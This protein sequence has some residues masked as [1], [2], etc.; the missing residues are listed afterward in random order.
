MTLTLIGR[1]AEQQQLASELVSHGCTGFVYGKGITFSSGIKS[2]GVYGDCRK[3]LS[4]PYLRK[5]ILQ[6]YAAFVRQYRFSSITKI[7]FVA[8]VETGGIGFGALIAHEMGLPYIGVRKE[9]KGHGDASWFSGETELV[10][11][12]PGLLVEDMTT[13][14][15]SLL[16]AQSTLLE[17]LDARV[18]D[19][20]TVFSYGFPE[21]LAAIEQVEMHV[22]TLCT[23]DRMLRFAVSDDCDTQIDPAYQAL[24]E[25]WL[26]N[27]HDES[28]V[29]DDWSFD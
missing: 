5:L 10:R 14:A 17:Q 27:P 23:F 24:I 2:P 19:A 13:T 16:R 8:G 7:E 28:W 22:R 11:D 6:Q 21:M 4:Y 26:K 18:S 3:A 15:G 20:L 12:L 1:P 9:P 29:T 25:R